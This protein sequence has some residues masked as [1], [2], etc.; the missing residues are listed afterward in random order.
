MLASGDLTDARDNN[1][2]GSR[3]YI[4]E[5]E[6]YRKAIDDSGILNRSIWMDIRGNHGTLTSTLLGSHCIASELTFVIPPTDNFNVAGS[7]SDSDLFIQYSVQGKENPRAY[8]K[9]VQKGTEKYT[10][11]AVDACLKPEGPK[12][13]FN[14]IG[15]LSQNDT[16]YL[17]HLANEA[18]KNGGNYT[19]W[20]GHYPTSCIITGEA[21]SHGLRRLIGD[22]DESYAY[23]CGHLHNF[24]GSVPRMFT[25]Q[26]D[27]FLELELGDW[28]KF[29]W[30]RLGAID[31]GLFSFVD[32][33]HNDFP[34]VLVT[35]PKNYMFNIPHREHPNLQKGLPED[36]IFRSL[37]P[38]TM[39]RSLFPGRLY[40]YSNTRLLNVTNKQLFRSH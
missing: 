5:W 35:N 28:K 15:V 31:H 8:M 13:P 24:G 14:F 40:S 25:L 19:I 6:T 23:L 36:R 2:F 38:D 4:G 12:R 16:N 11:I 32:T 10:F 29:R 37:T 21:G 22:Y 17:R 39:F 1:I 18:R 7:R 33:H 30:F 9:Q 3:Q 20:F 27:G 34:I 26:Q